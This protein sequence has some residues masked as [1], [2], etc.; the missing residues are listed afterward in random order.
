MNAKH[1]FVSAA[2]IAPLVAAFVLPGEKV[3]FA[4]AEG[5]SATKSFENKMELTL[6]HMAITMNGQEMP[7]MPE[8]D[9]T[10]TQT[11]KVGVTDEFVAMGDGQPKKLKRHFDALAS[12]SAMSMKMEMMGQSNN[13]DQNSEAE[14]ELDGK[15]VV[16]TW[17]AEAKEFKKAFDPAEDK[18]DLLKGLQEDMDLRA[19]LPESEVKV[20]DEWNVDVKS[21]ATVLAPGG[22][23]SFKPKDKEES[24]MG[25]G[26][27][28]GQGMGSMYDYLS[29]LLEGEAK[30]KLTDVRE[31]GGAKLAVIKLTVKIASQKDMTDLVKD[32]M[33]D[34]EMPGGMEIEFDHMDV[35]FKMEGEGELVWNLKTNQFASF[36]L[37]G[38]VHMNMDMAMK[39]SGQGQNM[40]MEQALEMS[41]TNTLTVKSK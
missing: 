15:T 8:M 30:A 23:L 26:M 2:L 38:P 13:Q 28:M 5:S 27:G 17:D 40:S 32:A 10:I 36:E 39:I 21:L 37:S 19:L 11:Q 41:G 3:R 20:G 4:P 33:K 18:A 22:D 35:D 25:M 7:G 16:F 9:M 1:L 31:E 12:D 24:G 14:S 6:D 34:Q 29:D